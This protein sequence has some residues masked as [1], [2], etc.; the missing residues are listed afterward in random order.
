MRHSDKSA[1]LVT[2]QRQAPGST[3]D[4]YLRSGAGGMPWQRRTLPTRMAN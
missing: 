2:C 3:P 1:S 4:Q